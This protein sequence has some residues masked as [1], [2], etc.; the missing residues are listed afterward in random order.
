[1]PFCGFNPKMVHGLGIFAQG[2]FEALG[3]IANRKLNL[4]L[5]ALEN[6]YQQLRKDGSPKVMSELVDWIGEKPSP[7][8]PDSV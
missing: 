5:E 1:M 2:L 3:A 4:F 7:S 6:R 8:K